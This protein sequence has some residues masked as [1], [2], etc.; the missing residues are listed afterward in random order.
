MDKHHLLLVSSTNA[1]Q[2]NNAEK[3][4][5]TVMLITLYTYKNGSE[6]K[7]TVP[8]KTKVTF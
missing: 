6:S 4:W 2:G 8:I 1:L 7:F 3:V 5:K